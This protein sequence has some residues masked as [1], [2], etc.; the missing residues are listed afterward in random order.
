MDAIQ[1]FVR[2]FGDRAAGQ[3]AVEYLE[4]IGLTVRLCF[5]GDSDSEG[6]LI[7]TGVADTDLLGVDDPGAVLADLRRLTGVPGVRLQVR[8]Y[9]VHDDYEVEV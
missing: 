6:G 4:Q 3:V 9:S 8:E 5:D 1:F 7:E 2:G